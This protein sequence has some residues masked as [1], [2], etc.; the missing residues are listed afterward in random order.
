MTRSLRFQLAARF[1]AGLLLVLAA[2]S[3]LGYGGLRATLDRELDATLLNVASIQAAALTD[4]SSARMSFHEWEIT[5]EEATQVQDLVRFMQVWTD[6]GESLLRT[7]FITSDL[8]IDTAALRAAASGELA[9][10]GGRFH[11]AS[12]RSLYYPLGRLGKSHARHV[13][14]VAAPLEARNRLLVRTALLL[15]VLALATAAGA[16]A[17][18]WW[19]AGRAVAPVHAIIGQAEAI[20]PGDGRH[21]IQAAAGAQEYQRLIDVLN[22]M[23]QRLDEATEAQR[24]FTADASHELRSPLTVLR[25]ELELASRRER[26]VAEYRAVID[27]ALEEIERL[28]RVAEDLLTLARSDAG[29]MEARLR[30]ADLVECA[31]R[32]VERL[33]PEALAR[34]ID[35]TL[36]GPD[37]LRG[38]YDPDLVCRVLWNLVGNAVKFT[39]AAGRV[40]LR[41][42]LEGDEAL[43]E[44]EDTGPGIPAEQLG[45]I[46]DR[47]YRADASWSATTAGTGLGL[48]IVRAIVQLHCGRVTAANRPGGGAVFR[49]SL[50][51]FDPL[52]DPRPAPV[53]GPE[54]TAP[55][56]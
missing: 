8:P 54:L 21:R 36:T 40:T 12:I 53:E 55:T 33:Q 37:R 30:Q 20:R 11:G 16:F 41:L 19:L 32:T 42:G 49:V 29:V 17:G 7:R 15:T 4:G 3:V 6:D 13:L 22:T 14:Q 23:L 18:G 39:P 38:F 50:P 10:G 1:T 24:Q 52:P 27:S 5:P 46:F 34:G 28:S 35:L 2:L 48:A 25:G 26:S 45:R 9:W 47:F 31:A 44:V 51:H 56:A 43:V